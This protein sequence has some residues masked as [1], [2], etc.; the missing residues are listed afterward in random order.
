MS[1]SR[2]TTDAV[3]RESDQRARALAQ[4]IFDRPLILEAGAG[5]GKTTALVAR[6]LAWCLGVGW[7]RALASLEPD[8][9]AR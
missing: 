5:T 6:V 9:D 8:D 2:S 3:L 7:D 1:A 4:R